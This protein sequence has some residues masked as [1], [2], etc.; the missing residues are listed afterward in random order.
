VKVVLTQLPAKVTPGIGRACSSIGLQ[1]SPVFVRI[2]P[3]RDADANRCIY[4]VRRA[5]ERGDGEVVLGW[6]ILAW[7]RVLV[8]FI[9]HAVLRNR[10][11]LLCITPDRHGDEQVLFVADPSI[12]F[13]AADPMARMPSLQV[14][15][16]P[17][18]DVAEFISVQ[19]QIRALKETFP[20]SSGP[21]LLTGA[22]AVALKRLEGL[23]VR[24]I[25][26]IALRTRKPNE[27]C[28]CDSGRKFR[29]CCQGEMLRAR[30]RE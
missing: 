22:D 21:L 30:Q 16:D 5:A 27:P 7:P 8:Q 12:E 9:G 29:K 25:R 2:E 19:E 6:K 14:A 13:D 4:N 24:L 15:L 26:E 28:V 3:A 11:R 23:Q 18:R 10:E 1:G 20:P 17:H